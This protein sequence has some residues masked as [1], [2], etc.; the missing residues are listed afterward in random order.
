MYLRLSSKHNSSYLYT[1]TIKIYFAGFWSG[2]HERTNPN[3]EGFFLELFKEVYGCDVAV[4]SYTD[5]D[6]LVENTQVGKSLRTSKEWRHTYLYSGESYLREDSAAYSCVL[7]GQRNNGNIVNVPLY[8]SYLFCSGKE[9]FVQSNAQGKTTVIPPKGIVTVVSNPHGKFRNSFLNALEKRGIPITYAGN[10]K[11]NIGGPFKPQYNSQEFL[12]YIN[13]FKFIISMENSEEDTYITEKIVHG[14]L[15]SSIP[16]YWGSKQVTNYFNSERIIEV[17]DVDT[18]I[19]RMM[20]MTD[21]D[22]LATVNKQPFTEFGKQYSIHTIAKHIRN[23]IIPKPFPLLTQVYIITNPI[24]EPARY[25]RCRAMC[26]SLGLSSD[27]VTFLCPTYKQLITSDIMK[28]YII[29]DLVKNIRPHCGTKKGELS[30]TLNFRAVYESIVNQYKD[31]M[32]LI[33]ES[34]AYSLPTISD[35]NKCLEH[36]SHKQWSTINIGSGL[37]SGSDPF[38]RLPYLHVPTPYRRVADIRLL[39]QHEKEDLSAAGDV[40]R[41]IRKFHTR[42]TDAQLFSYGGCKQMYEY[43]AAEQNYGVPFD[44][45]VIHKTEI[46]MG[47]KYYWSAIPYFDQLTNRGLEKSTLQG[48]RD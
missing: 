17:N 27:N 7:Y 23:L 8:V 18:A 41:Y 5:S 19:N 13:Q 11:N 24:F 2:F 39:S 44:Y 6:I 9:S 46:D 33:L 10:Y 34:D 21:E 48:D 3:H 40:N 15:G 37:D 1:M 31:G 32:F 4:S 25:E 43:M 30:L 20:T 29:S 35:F 22:W 36:L 45:Y 16:V 38:K 42:C 28:K 47:F 14:L 26:D 12:D